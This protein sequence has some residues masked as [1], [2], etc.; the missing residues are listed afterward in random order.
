MTGIQK[1]SWGTLALDPWKRPTFSR[2]SNTQKQLG[3]L[4]KQ[5]APLLTH[6]FARLLQDRRHRAQSALST[7]ARIDLTR[8]VV[9]ISLALESMRWGYNLSFTI[10]SQVLRLPESAGSI[11]DF[12]FGKTLRRS[13]EAVVVLADKD[14]H[15]S[16]RS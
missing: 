15:K 5:A 12:Q 4:V 13:A 8:D 3:V 16:A 10:G 11:F 6:D 7:S 2:L 1:R 14:T 9:L